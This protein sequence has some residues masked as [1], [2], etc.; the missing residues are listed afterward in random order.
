M[1]MTYDGFPIDAWRVYVAMTYW[2][3]QHDGMRNEVIRAL[4]SA[5]F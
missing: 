4:M 1:N 3:T 5:G 2:Y